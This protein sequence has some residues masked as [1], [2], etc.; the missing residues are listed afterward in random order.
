MPSKLSHLCCSC[1]KKRHQ[2]I[3]NLIVEN[4]YNFPVKNMWNH[5]QARDAMGALNLKGNLA[6][7]HGLLCTCKCN[8]ILQ[9]NILK[10]PVRVF[11]KFYRV[12]PQYCLPST[13]FKSDDG[14]L[15]V[16]LADPS[17]GGFHFLALNYCNL[18]IR[19]ETVA[20]PLYRTLK[21]QRHKLSA[22]QWSVWAT[23]ALSNEDWLQS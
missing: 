14:F 5:C 18:I 19:E 3:W 16:C 17:S 13:V 23:V 1:F 22:C 12:F 15:I 4:L 20:R 2:N 11:A 6:D 7:F 21:H 10:C 8:P 9:I